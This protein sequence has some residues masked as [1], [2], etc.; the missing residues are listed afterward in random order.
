MA[1]RARCQGVCA[2]SAYKKKREKQKQRQIFMHGRSLKG[3][4]HKQQRCNALFGYAWCR[5]VLKRKRR[6]EAIGSR[7][8][9]DARGPMRCCQPLSPAEYLTRHSE[10]GTLAVK[11]AIRL[12][13]ALAPMRHGTRLHPCTHI[14]AAAQPAPLRSAASRP[15]HP[16]RPARLPAP[17]TPC[18]RPRCWPWRR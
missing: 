4:H 12:G 5:S 9:E 18:L 10:G 7:S 6:K 3:R 16:P 2:V 11:P 1:C 8:G 14:P 17:H 13:S 15:S